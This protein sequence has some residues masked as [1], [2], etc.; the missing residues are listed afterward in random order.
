MA[1]G[2]EAAERERRGPDEGRDLGR[3][4][5]RSTIPRPRRDGRRPFRPASGRG[6]RLIRQEFTSIFGTSSSPAASALRSAVTHGSTRHVSLKLEYETGCQRPETHASGRSR[7]PR[8]HTSGLVEA[9]VPRTAKAA[10]ARAQ[11]ASRNLRGVHASGGGGGGGGGG[12]G[13]ARRTAHARTSTTSE[14]RRMPGT[15][16]AIALQVED[17][18]RVALALALAACKGG[19]RGADGAVVR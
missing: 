10:A 15:T 3:P 5:P 6:T 13:V 18:P 1:A 16:I 8:V 11:C 19:R 14:I 2:E 9:R 12:L 17:S 7:S 4:G